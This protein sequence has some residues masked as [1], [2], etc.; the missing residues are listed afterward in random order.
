MNAP[1]TLLDGWLLYIVRTC[2]PWVVSLEQL[3]RDQVATRGFW[4]NIEVRVT[5]M[6]R[7]VCMV[8][9]PLHPL[10][11]GLRPK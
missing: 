4:G 7:I 3:N 10:N 9:T 8:P 5:T 2:I 1:V 11:K 6:Y